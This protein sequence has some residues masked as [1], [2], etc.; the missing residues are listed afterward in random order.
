MFGLS[1]RTTSRKDSEKDEMNAGLGN[2]WPSL[3]R[4]NDERA[5]PGQEEIDLRREVVGNIIPVISWRNCELSLR[6]KSIN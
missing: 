2:D 3:S 5:K 6:D 4:V 1:E